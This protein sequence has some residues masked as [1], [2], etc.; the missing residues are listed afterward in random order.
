MEGELWTTRGLHANED[1]RARPGGLD[2][3]TPRGGQFRYVVD[4]VQ[5]LHRLGPKAS[6]VFLG[7]TPAPIAELTP[8][9][10]G[11]DRAWRYVPFVRPTGQG[12]M[13]WEQA[14]LAATLLRERAHLYHGLHTVIPILAPCPIVST[15]L[16]LMFELFP[17]YAAVIRSRSYRLYRWGMRNWIRRAI[18]I[19]QTT[20]D[21]AVRLWQIE[22]G[23]LDVV[24]LGTTFL[25]LPPATAA[26]PG[27]A[28]TDRVILSAY[29]L[30]PRKNLAGLVRS[31]AQIA[32]Q[33]NR[34]GSFCTAERP[35]HRSGS[36][37]STP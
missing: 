26:V 36:G 14:R 18:C 6:F 29:N 2:V 9:F 24:Y 13:F 19:S 7:G 30:E 37:H 21:D 3:A 15:V 32:T 1:D 33:P 27:V 31:F 4:L 10:A 28:A 23:R 22:R 20:A 34:A 25:D 17:E 16:D 12:A 8:L 35:F 11:G 5:G